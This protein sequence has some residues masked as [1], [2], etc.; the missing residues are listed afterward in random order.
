MQSFHELPQDIQEAANGAS[1]NVL[2][3]ESK[4]Q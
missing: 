4:E 3:K 1:M 2:Q